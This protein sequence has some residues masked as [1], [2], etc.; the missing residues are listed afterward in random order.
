MKYFQ[1]VTEWEDSTPNHIYYM[2]D[3]RSF[4]VGYIQQGAKELFK[5]KNPIRIDLRGR[6][7]VELK[8][9]KGEADSVYFAKPEAP[10]KESIIVKGSGG[11]EYVLEKVGDHYT[12]TCPGFMFRQKCKHVD[13]MK[14]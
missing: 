1:E 5:F 12:C 4:M 8:N 6:K 10:K 14:A 9:R 3:E 13:G 2:N 7:F 11:K